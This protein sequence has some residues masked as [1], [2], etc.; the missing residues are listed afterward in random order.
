MKKVYL[1]ALSLL[2]LF[3]A[4]YFYNKYSV[5]CYSV[6]I[7]VPIEH[8]ALTEMVD[9]FLKKIN[10]FEL[11]KPVRVVVQNA[12]GSSSEMRAIVESFKSSSFDV[13]IPVTASATMLAVG[14]EQKTPIIGLASRPN[15]VDRRVAKNLVTICDE[16][17]PC[18]HAEFI[19]AAFPFCN[20]ICVLHSCSEYILDDVKELTIAAKELGVAVEG[21]MVQSL[22]DLSAQL[23]HLPQDCDVIFI[24]KDSL[25]ASAASMISSAA[26]K[27]K[28]P[29]VSVDQGS[30]KIGSGLAMGVVEREVGE[31]GAECVARILKKQPV[32]DVQMQERLHIF[33]NKKHLSSDE[34]DEASLQAF[35]MNH[36]FVVEELT[37]F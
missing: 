19:K 34:F 20:K 33:W 24:L 30:A 31:V 35:A 22:V 1:A 26:K 7:V 10:S 12:N 15:V 25:M 2:S 18:L 17:S 27:L 29:F 4:F 9:G 5:D 14:L 36:G 21:F 28:K 8:Q 16:V 11:D 32:Q 23:Q 13:I 6:G 37:W 3:A